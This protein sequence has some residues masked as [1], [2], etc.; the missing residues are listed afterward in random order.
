MTT[1]SSV[2]VRGT[3]MIA[4]LAVLGTPA[5]AQG[6]GARGKQPA[7]APAPAPPAAPPQV[8][9]V[10]L[11]VVAPGLGANGSELKPFNESPGTVVVLAIQGSGVNALLEEDE[12]LVIHDV[13]AAA[14]PVPGAGPIEPDEILDLHLLL[15]DFEGSLDDLLKAPHRSR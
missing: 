9:A 7:A 5:L 15:K 2:L 6:R 8:S 3:V 11:R 14:R 10:G 12:E 13:L 4:S 1:R